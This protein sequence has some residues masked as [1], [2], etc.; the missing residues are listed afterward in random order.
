ML[1]AWIIPH[2]IPK[3][4]FCSGIYKNLWV[5]FTIKLINPFLLIWSIQAPNSSYLTTTHDLSPIHHFNYIRLI[6][7]TCMKTR[8]PIQ[9]WFHPT[10]G[11]EDRHLNFSWSSWPN[12]ISILWPPISS[13]FP[14]HLLKTKMYYLHNLLHKTH[15]LPLHSQSFQVD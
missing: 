9:I 1:S 2:V 8:T 11:S 15:H 14:F 10:V 13:H 6:R 3:V 12:T 5:F 4:F 7:T